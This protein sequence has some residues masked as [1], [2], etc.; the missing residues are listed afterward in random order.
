[1]AANEG[2]AQVARVLLDSGAMVVYPTHHLMLSQ[3]KQ[4][5]ARIVPTKGFKTTT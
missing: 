3:I 4:Y 2:H 5:R 1:M